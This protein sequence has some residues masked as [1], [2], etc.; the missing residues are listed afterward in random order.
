VS[1]ETLDEERSERECR[2]SEHA[3]HRF[4]H[5]T[6]LER[7]HH[8][9]LRAGLNG[10][11]HER[12]LPIALHMRTFA[13]GSIFVISRTASM[14]P[15]S[16][17]TMSIVTRSGAAAGT[18]RP[19]CTPVSASP[20]ISNPACCRMSPTIVR[21]KMASSQIKTVWLTS[22]SEEIRDSS[23]YL[24]YDCRDIEYNDDSVVQMSQTPHDSTACDVT[25]RG[26]ETVRRQHLNVSNLI[27]RQTHLL[28]AELRQHDGPVAA[29]DDPASVWRD[30]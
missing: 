14:P 20:T 24:A 9:V 23:H 7:L 25:R 16:G 26:L 3:L 4:Q 10:L 22:S 13:C 29:H 19:A 15:M 6:R 12:L 8:E 30:R 21:M 27:D 17:I 11:D 28:R 5:A 1:T 2:L 18:S